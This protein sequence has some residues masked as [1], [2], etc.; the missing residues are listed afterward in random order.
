MAIL[1]PSEIAY[2]ER[3]MN[4]N[5][6]TTLV[7]VC[8]FFTGAALLSLIARM[9]IRRLAKTSLGWDDVFAIAALVNA[10]QPWQWPFTTLS[11]DWVQ[12]QVPLIG[13][14]IAANLGGAH[15]PSAFDPFELICWR[16][17][18]RILGIRKNASLGC[19]ASP[20]HNLHWKSRVSCRLNSCFSHH[21]WVFMASAIRKRIISQTLIT[22]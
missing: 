15:L 22:Q 19:A 4:D 20:T 10:L 2:Q 3:L 18:S 13:L 5:H 14:N 16:S 6:I 7:I 8:N 9:K 17:K 11:A 21:H 1:P 12:I